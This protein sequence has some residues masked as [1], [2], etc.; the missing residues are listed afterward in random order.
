M[1]TN[2]M[3]HF[4][5]AMSC[6]LIMPCIFIIKHISSNIWQQED[7]APGLFLYT[8]AKLPHFVSSVLLPRSFLLDGPFGWFSSPPARH[9]E[10]ATCLARLFDDG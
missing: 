5:V 6:Q 3:F 7:A 1:K 8:F 2:V 9:T 10:L 4:S